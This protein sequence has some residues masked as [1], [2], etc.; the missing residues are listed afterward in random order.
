[1]NNIA[2]ALYR[3]IKI[4]NEI[5][6]LVSISTT[7]LQSTCHSAPILS[8]SDHPRQKKNDVMSIFK[9]ADLSHLGFQGS[10]NGFFEKPNYITSYKSSIDNI[11]L[12]CLVFEKI[13]FIL[14]FG[15]RQTDE[16]MDSS[17]DALSR[18]RCRERRLNNNGSVQRLQVRRYAAQED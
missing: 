15:D 16:Q 10:N 8:K 13:A 5:L 7:S 1:M 11:S 14:H 9:M 3:V 2:G 18:S 17:T 12:N 6:H 4:K